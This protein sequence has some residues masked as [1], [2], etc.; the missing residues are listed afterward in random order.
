M[1]ANN[2]LL[3][4]LWVYCIPNFKCSADAVIR[5]NRHIVPSIFYKTFYV[6]SF[7]QYPNLVC[8]NIL[9]HRSLLY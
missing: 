5:G 3:N 1:L 2:T 7:A 4:A 9:I 6:F 8:K